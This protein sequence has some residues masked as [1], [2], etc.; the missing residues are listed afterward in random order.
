MNEGLVV[1][2]QN[3]TVLAVN[4]CVLTLFQTKEELV[5]N[6]SFLHLTRN[7]ELNNALNRA[8][9]GEKNNI[10]VELSGKTYQVFYSPVRNRETI[11]GVVMLLFDVSVRARAEPD[12]QG[13]FRQCVARA[14]NAAYYHLRLCP[15]AAARHCKA[16]GYAELYR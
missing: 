16:G 7:V 5:K 13:I 6:Q 10:D 2:D 14:E 11:S 8:L 9:Q 3:G 4:N 1:V 12:P 15:A